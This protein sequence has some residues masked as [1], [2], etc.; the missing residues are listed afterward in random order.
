MRFT[1]YF[2]CL[3]C[4]FLHCLPRPLNLYLFL[5]LD[6]SAMLAQFHKEDMHV[7]RVSGGSHVCSDVCGSFFFLNNV[8]S[9]K[10]NHIIKIIFYVFLMNMNVHGGEKQTTFCMFFNVLCEFPKGKTE[11]ANTSY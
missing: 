9:K 11:L 8:V 2:P 10:M 1:F 4:N 5:F 3:M 7:C 6:P